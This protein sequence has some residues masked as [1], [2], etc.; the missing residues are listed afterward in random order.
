MFPWRDFIRRYSL[1]EANIIA[2]VILSVCGVLQS[3]NISFF[4]IKRLKKF[5]EF[6]LF[7]QSLELTLNEQIIYA[8]AF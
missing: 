6:E 1:T 7:E 5:I 2:K 8:E 4:K 3:N